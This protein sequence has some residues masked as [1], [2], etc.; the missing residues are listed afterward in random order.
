MST[1]YRWGYHEHGGAVRWWISPFLLSMVTVLLA[2]NVWLF[3][4]AWEGMTIT[5]FFLVTTEHDRVEVQRA[6]YIYLVMSQMSAMLILAGMLQMA[7]QLHTFSFS[8]WTLRA[9]ALPNT[10]KNLII[11]LLGMGFAIKSG[12][13]PFHIWLPRAHPVAPAPVSSLMSGV[14]IKLGIFGVLQFL[15]FDLRPI[16]TFWPMVLLAAGAVSSL[17]GVLYALMEHDLKRLLAYHSIE[18]VGI[19]LLGI[20][21]MGIGLNRH[22]PA[23]AA[24]GL[25]ASLFHTLNH[26]VFKSQ[27]FLAAG[28]V[29]QHSGTLDADHLGGLIRTIPAIAVGFIAG[30]LAISAL[31]PFNGFVSEW[32]TLRGLLGL[33]IHATGIL[34]VYGLGL[35]M[36]LGLTGALAGLCFVK[37]SGVIFLGEARRPVY[38]RRIPI[39]MTGPVWALAAVSL[40]LGI[41]PNPLV[42]V[43][44]AILPGS[45]PAQA[46]AAVTVPVRPLYTAALILFGVVFFV[47]ISRVWDVRTVPR[48]ACGRVPDASM[49]ITSASFTKAIRTTFAVIYRPHRELQALGPHVPDFPAQL[50]YQGGT[51]PIWERYI[52]RPLYRGVWTASRLSTHLQAGP[53]RL[54]LAYLLATVGVMLAL[55]H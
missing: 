45:T 5:S 38:H 49:Q 10:S 15:L 12:V 44:T 54:Y 28:A 30:S 42:R 39:S 21:V 46:L 2:N 50:I 16:P 29:E 25:A 34:A 19:I 17:L 14:M 31:P 33:S 9:G 24:L 36:V 40:A 18:N 22:L 55:L 1:W 4:T 8:T 51:R 41:F 7:T 13:V 52:Y 26:A 53:V 47:L 11:A 20:G 23:L 6:G 3:M 27:L 48:W 43:F 32:L 37:A 35:A